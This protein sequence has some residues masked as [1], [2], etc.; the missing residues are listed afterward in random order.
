MNE[1]GQSQRDALTST[2]PSS[3]PRAVCPPSN[4]PQAKWTAVGYKLLS[5]N[6]ITLFKAVVPKPAINQ[7]IRNFLPFFLFNKDQW[8]LSPEVLI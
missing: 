2:R 5:K 1:T 6:P 7:K 8:A 4:L 3:D